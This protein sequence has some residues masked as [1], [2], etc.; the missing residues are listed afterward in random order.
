[1]KRILLVLTVALLAYLIFQNQ[2]SLGQ[3]VELKCFRFHV[4]LVLGL[5]LVIGFLSG[6]ALLLL[7][8]VP[9]NLALRREL[10]KKSQELAK[11]K[12]EWAKTVAASPFRNPADPPTGI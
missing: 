5:W 2:A 9:R 12:I 1:M 3:S 6:A 4:T 10:R 11:L 7:I 8:D